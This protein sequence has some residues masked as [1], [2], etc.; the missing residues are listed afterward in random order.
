MEW[1]T[2]YYCATSES[3]SEGVERWSEEWITL[4]WRWTSCRCERE[5]CREMPTLNSAAGTGVCFWIMPHCLFPVHAAEEAPVA[6]LNSKTLQV[7]TS[8]TGYKFSALILNFLTH[9][10]HAMPVYKPRTHTL[11]N[12]HIQK[13]LILLVYLCFK[14]SWSFPKFMKLYWQRYSMCSNMPETVCKW[15]QARL[16]GQAITASLIFVALWNSSVY[17]LN[18]S[19]PLYVCSCLNIEHYWCY[20]GTTLMGLLLVN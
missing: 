3:V 1:E 4:T 13:S 2:L 16:K 8:S 15:K 19:F 14:L 6:Y 9:T 12:S 17:S 7:K 10:M 20:V 11:T 5:S 18:A